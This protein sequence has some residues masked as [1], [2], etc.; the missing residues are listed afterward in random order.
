MRRQ[1]LPTFGEDPALMMKSCATM[2]VHEPAAQ[3]VDTSTS[4]GV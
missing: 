2:T 3:D 4:A 1:A